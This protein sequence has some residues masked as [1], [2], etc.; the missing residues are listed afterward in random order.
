MAD[1]QQYPQSGPLP[2]SGTFP[3]TGLAPQPPM[4]NNQQWQPPSSQQ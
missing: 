4:Y 1:F 2:Q 3:Q